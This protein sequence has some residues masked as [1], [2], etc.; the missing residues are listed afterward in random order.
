[1][2]CSFL[3]FIGIDSIIRDIA[4]DAETVISKRKSR[5]SSSSAKPYN[6]SIFGY[7]KVNEDPYIFFIARLV[8]IEGNISR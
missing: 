3:P 4:S 6:V 1:M 2:Q 8:G 7:L 5:L